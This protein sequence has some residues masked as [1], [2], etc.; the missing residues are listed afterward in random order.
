[1]LNIKENFQFDIYDSS[2]SVSS[3]YWQLSN[4]F[5]PEEKIIWREIAIY[6]NNALPIKERN[7]FI[8]F[9]QINS[10]KIES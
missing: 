4:N 8:G 10:S 3:G 5:T 2:Y 6:I 9:S 7:L 1:M